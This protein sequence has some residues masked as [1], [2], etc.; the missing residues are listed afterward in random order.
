MSRRFRL[1]AVPLL[2]LSL[3]ASVARATTV[4]DLVATASS[5]SAEAT[6]L[7]DDVV[8]DTTPHGTLLSRLE[9]L[10]TQLA[11]LHV[12]RNAL[13]QCQ[14]SSLDSQISAIDASAAATRVIVDQWEGT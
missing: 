8:A 9:S 12:Q 13:G 11:D 2:A 3:L 6:S 1:L 14:C 7:H 4:D 5:L 10:E